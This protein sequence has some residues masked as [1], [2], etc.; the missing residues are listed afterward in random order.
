MAGDSLAFNGLVPS[1]ISFTYNAVL[2]HSSELPSKEN[3][4]AEEVGSLPP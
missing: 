3:D 4:N 2:D 1:R